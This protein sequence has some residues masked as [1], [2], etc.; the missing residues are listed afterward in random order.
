VKEEVQND[1]TKIEASIAQM[2]ASGAD[3]FSEEIKNLQIKIANAKAEAEAAIDTVQ[4]TDEATQETA[5]VG[6][7][8]TDL[9]KM[10][11]AIGVLES[12]GKD[13]FSDA[14]KV[15]QTKIDA[16]EVAVN[17][18]VE[19]AETVEENFVQKYGVNT[20]RAM[21]IILLLVILYKLF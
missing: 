18:E 19:K 2:Q 14:I 8:Q 9:E 7:E 13:L 5:T 15:I 20:A 3:L 12:A 6:T 11:T 17:S 10:K 21:E 1:I 4:I 16:A